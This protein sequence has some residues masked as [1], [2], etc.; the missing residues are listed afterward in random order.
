MIQAYIIPILRNHTNQIVTVEEFRTILTEVVTMSFFIEQG[1]DVERSKETGVEPSNQFVFDYERI[2]YT[3][4]NVI[5]YIKKRYSVDNASLDEVNSLCVF[6]F[7]IEDMIRDGIILGEEIVE[8]FSITTFP[9]KRTGNRRILKH[10][11]L[12]F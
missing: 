8:S 2:R 11:L 6:D 12:S 4:T 3:Y 1:K 10:L 5:D 7:V 9:Y